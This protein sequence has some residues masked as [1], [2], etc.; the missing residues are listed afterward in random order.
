MSSKAAKAVGIW[1]VAL[2][3]IAIVV[4][5]AI[6]EFR[7]RGT[8]AIGGFTVANY[9]ASPETQNRP[10]PDFKLPSLGGGEPIVLS[11]FR[12]H[13]LVLNF[14]GSWCGPCRLE[15]PGLRWVS[16]HY[17]AQGVRFLGVDERDND[18]AGRAFVREF[19]WQYP[20]ASDPA[21][22]LA[23]DYRLIGFPT[24]FIIDPQGTIRYRFQGYLDRDVLQAALDELLSG[25]SP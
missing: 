14:W 20:S 4:A 3:A 9:K 1:L 23:D 25:S 7:A 13:V 17:Q 6:V 21:G 15:A 10:A 5:L 22:S 11:S 19:G 12:G 18:A 8:A 2:S 24:T 16:E